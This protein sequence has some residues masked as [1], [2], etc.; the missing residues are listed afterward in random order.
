MKRVLLLVVAFAS[1]VST[2]SAWSARQDEA[3]VI[4]ATKHL[5]SEALALVKGYLGDR[6]DDDVAYLYKL[7]KNHQSPYTKSVHKL[8]F[9]ADLTLASIEGDDALKA[10]EEA[11]R[12][13]RERKNHDKGEVT[14]ALRTIINLMCDIHNFSN[15]CIEGIPHSYSDFKFQVVGGRKGP[16]TMKWS[17]FFP[18][19][20][21]FH[22]GYSAAYWAED[23]EI[24]YGSTSG[25]LA[26]GTLRDWAA[27]IGAKAA[28]LYT[29]VYPNKEMP[30][31]DRLEYETLGY[32]MVARTGYRLAALLNEL[33]K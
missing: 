4:L 16:R 26:T 22:N 7:E 15:I 19:Y 8:H 31:R 27:Q 3:T 17:Q 24:Y 5:T 21:N 11:M 2:A 18:L 25:E 12:V 30:L 23:F 33:A 14:L 6:Y 9:S 32:E 20:A 28:E 10:L 13:V 1:M 29:E